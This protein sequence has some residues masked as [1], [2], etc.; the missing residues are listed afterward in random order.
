MTAKIN[1]AKDSYQRGF[2][3]CR[4]QRNEIEIVSLDYS[5][6]M[7]QILLSFGNL[8]FRFITLIDNRL[9]EISGA[10]SSY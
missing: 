8:M 9:P 1:N 3:I 7:S 4:L 5:N 6:F 2:T 10:S